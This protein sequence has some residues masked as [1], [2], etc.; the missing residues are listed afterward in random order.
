[1]IARP[2][3]HTAPVSIP[4]PGAKQ[5]AGWKHA[6]PGKGAQ[7]GKQLGKQPDK[8]GKAE[9]GA[10]ARA[11]L[12]SDAI[13]IAPDRVYIALNKPRNTITT[14]SDPEGRT[15]VLDLVEL[16][17]NYARRIFPVGR[18]DA[19]STGLLILTN[20]GELA[21]RLTHPRYGVVK[22]YLV[23]VKGA[24]T[25]AD[26]EQLQSGLY[27]AHP[28]KGRGRSRPPGAGPGAERKSVELLGTTAGKPPRPTRGTPFSYDPQRDEAAGT[29]STLN[30]ATATGAVA[31]VRVKKAAMEDVVVLEQQRD[32]TRGDRTRLL[33]RLRE[34]QNREIRRLMARLGFKVR[35]LQRV[36]IGPVTLKGLPVG[37]W[38]MLT[39]HEVR[40]LMRASMEQT[41]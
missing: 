32:V 13:V 39:P 31:G 9:A 41:E 5:A 7:H 37:G 24:L 15:S 26:V 38:R 29:A 40:G 18:L 16:P 12:K 35:R 6:Q 4:I 20:D 17:P 21:N 36:A 19:D 33:V 2:S 25:P 34:G 22:E 28:T 27:L 10:A 8:P 3:K 1:M 14:A 11:P 23:S 30:P